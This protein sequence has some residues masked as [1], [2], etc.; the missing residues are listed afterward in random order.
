MSWE[1]VVAPR[2]RGRG[3]ARGRAKRAGNPADPVAV[4]AGDAGVPA[5]RGRGR[6]PSGRLRKGQV[7]RGLP[8][9]LP[10]LLRMLHIAYKYDLKS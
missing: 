9:P 4:G 7:A 3:R 2:P 5:G 6:A 8:R 1:L 10:S